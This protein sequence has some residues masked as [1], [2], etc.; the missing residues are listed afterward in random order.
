MFLIWRKHT[1][2]CIKKG[3]LASLILTAYRGRADLLPLVVCQRDALRRHLEVHNGGSGW[4]RRSQCL[5][6]GLGNRL[7]TCQGLHV[8]GVDVEHVACW[9]ESRRPNQ[10]MRRNVKWDSDS[11]R[12]K[13]DSR[14]CSEMLLMPVLVYSCKYIDIV[15]L[16]NMLSATK[17][18][19]NRFR[20]QSIQ[21]H[22]T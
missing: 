16:E 21:S 4:R 5:R 7:R 1:S 10:T 8:Y 13:L 19:S 18:G 11:A 6:Y 14:I 9:E 20:N 15:S 2:S 22:S 3:T 12:E 17:L